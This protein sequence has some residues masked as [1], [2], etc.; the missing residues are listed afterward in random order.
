MSDFSRPSLQESELLNSFLSLQ[1]SQFLGIVMA[2]EAGVLET[3]D[4]FLRI[5]GV[6]RE[7]FEREGIDWQ[8]ITPPEHLERDYQALNQLRSDGACAPY[9]KDYVL[10]DGRRIQILIG[11]V[12]LQTE[13]LTWACYILDMSEHKRAAELER[14]ARELAARDE[15][16]HEL[17]HR[18]NNPLAVVTNVLYLL[19]Q[20]NGLTQSNKDF[21]SSALD[22]LSEATAIARMMLRK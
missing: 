13:P 11:A 12:R 5:I 22:S 20:D 2:T 4:A 10:K 19:Q 18:I 1:R 8:A 7:E 6:T 14:R 17:A 15:I 21:L 16:I 3:N 9:E